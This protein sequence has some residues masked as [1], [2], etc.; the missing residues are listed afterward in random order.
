MPAMSAETVP[1]MRQ[2]LVYSVNS[3]SRMLRSLT[4]VRFSSAALSA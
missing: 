2:L 1:T 4:L 3:R